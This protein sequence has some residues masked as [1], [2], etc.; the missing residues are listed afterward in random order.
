MSPIPRPPPVADVIKP[1]CRCRGTYARW[2][3]FRVGYRTV[4]ANWCP[5][6]RKFKRSG[7]TPGLRALYRTYIEK[8]P[9]P[10]FTL[11]KGGR[12]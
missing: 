11:L 4:Q 3:W 2:S 10:K 7:A 5:K 6:C 12:W 9:P 8:N 1:Y